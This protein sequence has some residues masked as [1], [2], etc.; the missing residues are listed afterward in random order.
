MVFTPDKVD[1]LGE[2]DRVDNSSLSKAIE[3]ETFA[4][5]VHVEWDPIAAVTPIGQL[6]F[7]SSFSNWDIALIPGW[8]TVHCTTVQSAADVDALRRVLKINNAVL[9]GISYGTRLALTVMKLYP[10]NIHTA[11]LDSVVPPQSG[12]SFSESKIFGA[13]LD[14]LFQACQQDESCASAYPELPLLISD[15]AQGEYTSLKFHIENTVDNYRGFPNSFDVGANLAVNC[16]DGV[17]NV[18][19][20]PEA[21]NAGPYP[22]LNDFVAANWEADPCAIWPTKPGTGNRDAV[23]SEIPTLLLAGGLYVATT[24]EQAEVAAETLSVSHL[25]IFPA[26]AHWQ[27]NDKCAWKI[28]DEF[29]SHPTKRPNPECLTSLRQ[30]SFLTLERN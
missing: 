21:R 10:D 22:Y 28:I 13:V 18:S 30:P 6:P 5:K 14:R 11:I 26:N 7:L 27:V 4:G 20:Q 17:D 12:H 15:V 16:N 1:P 2:A 8:K 25:F 29:L 23:S 3:F 19:R 9:F 24:V